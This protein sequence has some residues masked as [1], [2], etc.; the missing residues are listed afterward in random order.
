MEWLRIQLQIMRERGMK[1]ILMGHVPPARVDSKISWD[2]TCWQKY[3]L[4]MQQ[5][6]DIV[7][8]S[9]YGHMNIDH[10]MLQDFKD[11]KKH[12]KKGVAMADQS[13]K[14]AEDEML[15]ASA[16]AD[17]L[18]DLRD[19]FARIPTISNNRIAGEEHGGWSSFFQSIL[20]GGDESAQKKNKKGSGKDPLSKIGGEYGERYSLSL[21]SSSVVPNYLP[22]LRVFEY[23]ITGLEEH[24][25]PESRSYLGRGPQSGFEAGFDTL[26]FPLSLD[27]TYDVDE[28]AYEAAE[29]LRVQRNREHEARR[30]KP[31]RHKFKLPEPPSKSAPPGPAYSPQTL[32]LLGYTHY[33]A[34]LT[35]INNDFSQQSED[36]DAGANRWKEGRHGGK[37]PKH[38]KPHPKTFKFQ[39]EYDTFSDKVYKLKDLTVR[40]Y[41][42]LA[43]EIAASKHGGKHASSEDGEDDADLDPSSE[44][45]DD[46][47]EP[48]EGHD[49][50]QNKN[51]KKKHKGKKG[52]KKRNRVW[53]AFIKRAFVGMMDPN[54]IEE[55]FGFQ[56]VDEEVFA[57]SPESLE[58]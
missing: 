30:K 37:V 39:V 24:T 41:I 31:R 7:L 51:G 29:I 9:I 58:L 1:A 33:A 21:V 10:F 6:R 11:V 48:E 32:S 57:E 2:E 46:E 25:I 12:L 50:D 4:W 44:D 5:Y 55:V 26:S 53:F 13:S 15:N 49:M 23:N 20:K 22:T 47:D 34:N 17:Y 36:D 54:D 28:S 52:K 56:N 14:Q 3:T 8:A 43:K 40:S 42:R 35:H 19:A 18:V 45:E 16:S 27:D 38:D